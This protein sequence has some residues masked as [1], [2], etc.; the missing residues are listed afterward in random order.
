[1]TQ[2]ER[3]IK[4]QPVK[5]L[6]LLLAGILLGAVLLGG[7]NIKPGSQQNGPPL[8]FQNLFCRFPAE[9]IIHMLTDYIHSPV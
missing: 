4:I 6:K 5:S 7:G 2:K 1:M 9:A 8:P 3:K